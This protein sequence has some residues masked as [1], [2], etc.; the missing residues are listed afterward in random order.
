MGA[1]GTGV[2]ASNQ[3][4]CKVIDFI[5]QHLAKTFSPDQIK[6]HFGFIYGGSINSHN[7]PELLKI[8]VLDGFLVGAS[9]LIPDELE[10]ILTIINNI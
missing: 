7:I 10:K 6:D 1:V 4:I 3:Q 8:S 5:G 2:V 9:S